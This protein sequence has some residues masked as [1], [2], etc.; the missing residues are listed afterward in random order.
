MTR[1]NLIA[2]FVFVPVLFGNALN[3]LAAGS[4]EICVAQIPRD[5]KRIDEGAFGP[6]AIKPLR[7][8]F[9]IQIGKRHPI[10]IRLGQPSRI[11]KVELDKRQLVRIRD[12]TKVLESFWYTFSSVGKQRWCLVYTPGYQ[13]WSLEPTEG[14]KRPCH[15]N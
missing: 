13:T 8:E 4:G 10:P 11:S 5:I 12:G 15:C 14:G 2:Y 1:K 7:Y 6:F 3:A 9:S